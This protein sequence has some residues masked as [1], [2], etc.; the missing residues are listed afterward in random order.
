MEDAA[1][2]EISRAQVWQWLKHGAK[3]ED[4]RAVTPELVK[5]TI[6][7]VL[8]RLRSTVGAERFEK[9]KYELAAR[10]FEKMMLSGEFNQFLTL[11][12]YEYLD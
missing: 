3:L 11:P 6:A 5:Q 7:S 9:G 8:D 1:T 2:A 10:I 12:A 4:G